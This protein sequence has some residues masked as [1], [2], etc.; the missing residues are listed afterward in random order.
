MRHLVLRLEAPLMSFGGE[1]VDNLGVSD[2]FPGASLLTGLFAN[3]L[4]WRHVELPLHQRLQDRLVF[5]ARMDREPAGGGR[6]TDFQT[7]RLDSRA[8]GWTRRGEPEGRQGSRQTRE[9]THLRWREYHADMC[10]TVALRLERAEPWPTLDDLAGALAEPRRPLF[11]GRKPCLPA[12]PMFGG[13]AEGD[14]A[15]RALLGVPLVH[16]HDAPEAVPL[17]WPV[18]DGAVPSSVR[19][20]R[21]GHLAGDLRNW[22]VSG[23]HGGGRRVGEGTV[24]RRH[25]T[26]GTS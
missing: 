2:S 21:S 16:P 19:V 11:I 13:Y 12:A 7:A 14:T 26:E 17:S 25:W 3:A 18:R 6:L 22:T 5:A 1:V 9:S 15:L 23:L 10:V 24:A 4:G 8:R 20:S